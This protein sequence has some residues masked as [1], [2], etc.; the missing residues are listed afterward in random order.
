[1]GEDILYTI[2]IE[3]RGGEGEIPYNVSIESK[4]PRV[5]M[6]LYVNHA[7]ING[8]V[9]VPEGSTR[10]IR[11]N[12]TVPRTVRFDHAAFVNVSIGNHSR[13]AAFSIVPAFNIS[14]GYEM[15]GNKSMTVRMV[16][17][18]RGATIDRVNVSLSTSGIMS[19]ADN[20]TKAAPG[21]PAGKNAEF[22]WLLNVTG[23]GTGFLYFDIEAGNA[24]SMHY[25]K[26]MYITGA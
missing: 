7:T 5:T 25:K 22:V 6:A 2:E 21:I 19:V 12:M 10:E 15:S 13:E 8:S 1:M 14:V 23:E 9:R 16:M 20:D 26:A 24:G 18:N 4:N 3:N 17:S 11:G